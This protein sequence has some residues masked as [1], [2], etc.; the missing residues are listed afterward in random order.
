MGLHYLTP[1]ATESFVVAFL[2]HKSSTKNPPGLTPL[3]INKLAFLLHG[4]TLGCLDNPLFDNRNRQIQAWRYGPVVVDIYHTLKTFRSE[5]VTLEKIRLRWEANKDDSLKYENI[6]TED[7]QKFSSDDSELA[8]ILDNVYDV[9][10]D[11]GGGQLI[12][13]TH[14]PDGP[15]DQC[16]PRGLQRWG[17]LSSEKHIP[18]R[19]IRTYYADLAE[20]LANDGSE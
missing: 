2:L 12:N 15:W 1:F 13:L 6:L 14:E 8:E 11:F 20:V 17:F 5:Q 3:Q 4:W 16:R 7:V 9:Y 19:V 10:G 18:D